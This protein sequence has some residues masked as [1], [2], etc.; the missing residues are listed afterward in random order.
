MHQRTI[1]Q[2]P[3][4]EQQHYSVKGLNSSSISV[5]RIGTRKELILEVNR[6]QFTPIGDQR[7]V[8]PGLTANL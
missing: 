4:V 1:K 7:L 5:N 3:R 6:Q 8:R 2:E